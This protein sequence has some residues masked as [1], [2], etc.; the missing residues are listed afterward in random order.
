M[1]KPF[2]G[3]PV[4][5]ASIFSRQ[6]HRGLGEQAS[7]IRSRQQGVRYEGHRPSGRQKDRHEGK[8]RTFHPQ[9]GRQNRES[10]QLRKRPA[11]A[12]GLGREVGRPMGSTYGDVAFRFASALR[13]DR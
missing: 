6:R 2:A 10:Q 11:P 7:G 8:N 3:K 12:E 4:T 5:W 1:L 13:N 9:Q